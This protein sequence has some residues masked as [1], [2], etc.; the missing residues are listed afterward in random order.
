MPFFFQ[1]YQDRFDI[2]ETQ[3]KEEIQTLKVYNH[4]SNETLQLLAQEDLQ[5]NTSFQ[6]L[7]IELARHQE[8]LDDLDK[9]ILPNKIW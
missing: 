4:L 1:P 2:L 8:R 5:F 7:N 6:N 3:Q 9:E